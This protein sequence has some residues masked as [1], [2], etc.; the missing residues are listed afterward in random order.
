[1]QLQSIQV[2]YN[3]FR[4]LIINFSFPWDQT[5]YVGYVTE[6]IATV[7]I[8]CGYLILNGIPLLLFISI[9]LHHR[10]FYRVF[11][12]KID[13]IKQWDEIFLCDLVRFHAS[14]KK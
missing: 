1:M 9:C 14:V 5:T 6:I 8:V 13:K 4:S 11:K 12:Q 2:V 7:L 10:A 3:L